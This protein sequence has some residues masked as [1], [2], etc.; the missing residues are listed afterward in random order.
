MQLPNKQHF[1]EALD[2]CQNALIVLPKNPNG[3][4]LGSALALAGYLQKLNKNADIICAQEDFQELSFLPGI[5]KIRG[6]TELSNSFVISISTK[7]TKV[8]EISYHSFSDRI[9][10]HIKPEQGNF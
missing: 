8:D 4:S 9:D 10:V 1:F 5:N 7:N 2:K 3:D 6:G